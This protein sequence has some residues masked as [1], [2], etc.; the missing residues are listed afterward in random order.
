[1]I[2]EEQQKSR[3]GTSVHLSDLAPEGTELFRRDGRKNSENPKTFRVLQDATRQKHVQ[4]SFTTTT[5]H[6]P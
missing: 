3:T 6:L 2:E 1:M 5:Y 4:K